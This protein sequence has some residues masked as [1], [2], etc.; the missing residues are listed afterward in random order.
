MILQELT[1]RVHIGRKR[2]VKIDNQQKPFARLFCG[3]ETKTAFYF[4]NTNLKPVYGFVAAPLIPKTLKRAYA[5]VPEGEG[6][7]A[8]VR[9]V[10]LNYFKGKIPEDL[11]YSLETLRNV[12]KELNTFALPNSKNISK[13]INENEK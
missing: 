12:E 8:C 9:A 3:T 11:T 4:L 6:A 5:C 7:Y 13:N 1:T 2:R 10:K